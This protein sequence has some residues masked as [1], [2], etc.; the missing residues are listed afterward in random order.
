MATEKK[1]PGVIGMAKHN[2]VVQDYEL[3][4]QTKQVE[5][6]SKHKII[7]ELTKDS[8]RIRAELRDA[9]ETV[10]VGR[11]T[12]TNLEADYRKSKDYWE[13]NTKILHEEIARLKQQVT[14]FKLSAEGFERELNQLKAK[15]KW[16]QFFK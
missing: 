5:I 1:S 6:D 3:Q 10:H 7:V 16:Y 15:K 9:I 13:H 11:I 4:L 12:L 2:A 14:C 8:E